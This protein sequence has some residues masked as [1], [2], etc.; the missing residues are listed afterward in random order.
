MEQ[1]CLIT[2]DGTHRFMMAESVL[3]NEFDIIVIPTLREISAGCGI[4]IK[5]DQ[6]FSE[7]ACQRLLESGLT[8]EMF[9]VWMIR[10]VNGVID[11]RKRDYSAA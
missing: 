1:Y 11:P 2:F 5:M 7:A 4:S 6:K 10:I 9:N 3:K 8:K